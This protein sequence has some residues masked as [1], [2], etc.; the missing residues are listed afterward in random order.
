VS[1]S[2]MSMLFELCQDIWL[3][4]KRHWTLLHGLLALSGG[5]ILVGLTPNA[6]RCLSTR[7]LENNNFSFR[8]LPNR[9][10]ERGQHVKDVKMYLLSIK[11]YVVC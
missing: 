10:L 5:G 2:E 6:M 9:A 3:K 4:V 1:R 8:L 7:S 11:T